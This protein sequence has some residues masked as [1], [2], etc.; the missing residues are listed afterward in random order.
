MKERISRIAGTRLAEF[1]FAYVGRPYPNTWRFSRRIGGVDQYV[2]F[3]KSNLEADSLRVNLSTSQDQ[4]GVELASITE[5]AKGPSW[6]G[7]WTY[8]DDESLD[9]VLIEL[10]DL[11][12]RFGI[13]WLDNCGGPFI[14]APEQW[15]KDLL[16]DPTGRARQ[17]ASRYSLSLADESCLDSVERMLL[18]QYKRRQGDPDWP[19]LLDASAFVGEFYRQELGGEWGWDSQMKTPAIIGVGGNPAAKARPLSA[20]EGLWSKRDRVRSLL[21]GYEGLRNLLYPPRTTGMR[22]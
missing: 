12:V 14:E 19:L 3:Q 8:H 7:W 18:E 11:T 4:M 20:I 10:A 13:P 2:T 1:G 17:F 9:S 5:S 15:S 16:V 21:L 6:T 22:H